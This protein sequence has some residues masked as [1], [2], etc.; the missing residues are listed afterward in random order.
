[1]EQLRL[2]FFRGTDALVVLE[3]L[4]MFMCGQPAIPAEEEPAIELHPTEVAMTPSWNWKWG[5]NFRLKSYECWW[6]WEL[7]DGCWTGFWCWF[8]SILPTGLFP[9]IL[10]R[11]WW[12]WWLQDGWGSAEG[13]DGGGGVGCWPFGD[14]GMPLNVYDKDEFRLQ[15]LSLLL[16]LL[17]AWSKGIKAC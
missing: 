15:S 4:L 16:L 7:F 14:D 8:G 13:T 3:L 11:H 9:A 6:T 2:D 10:A 12:S 17:S 5:D 1:M